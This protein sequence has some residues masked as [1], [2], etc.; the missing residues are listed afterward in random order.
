MKTH[1]FIFL[2]ALPFLGL[3]SCIKNNP[4]PAWLEVGEWTLEQNANSQYPT[5]ELTHNFTD[6]WVYVNDEIVGVFEVPFKIPLLYS[7]AANIKIFPAIRNNGISATKKMYQFVDVFEVNVDLKKNETISLNPVTRYKSSVRFWLEEFELAAVK[8]KNDPVAAAELV[9]GNDPSILKWGNY[10]GL[11][12]LSKVDS[13][14]IGYTEAQMQLPR[15]QEVYL[16]LDYYNTNS[17]TTGVIGISASEIKPNPNITLNKQPA[18]TVKWKKV[19]IDLRDI[20]SNSP[21]AEYFEQSFEAFIEAN[22]QQS[23]IIFDNVKV[24]YF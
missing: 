17:L 4:D 14:W 20:V 11:V 24:V 8:I 18:S 1:L 2:S 15:G 22:L 10:Y 16:E 7:G 21:N 13:T 19:Y 12:N 5:G 3:V 23:F 6:A 9:K